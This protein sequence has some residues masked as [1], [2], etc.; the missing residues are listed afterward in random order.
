MVVKPQLAVMHLIGLW[1][2]DAREEEVR[3]DPATGLT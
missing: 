2:E 1:R 3:A